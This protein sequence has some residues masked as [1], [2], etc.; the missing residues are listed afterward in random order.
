MEVSGRY[1]LATERTVDDVL[2]AHG[3]ITSRRSDPRCSPPGFKQN[4]AKQPDVEPGWGRGS[5]LT[6]PSRLLT[7]LRSSLLTGHRVGVHPGNESGLGR[8]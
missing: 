1:I 4:R 2:L 7:N 6:P 3:R 5:A 8:L